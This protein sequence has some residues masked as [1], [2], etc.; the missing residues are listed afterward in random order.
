M[1]RLPNRLQPAWP[2]VKRLHRTGSLLSGY[3]VRRGGRLRGDRALPRRASLTSAATAEREPASVTLHQTGTVDAIR[4][5]MPAGTPPNHWV[6][7]KKRHIDVPARF[8]LE[9]ADGTVVGDYGANIT[10]AGTLDYETSEYFGISSWR[11]HPIFLRPRLPPIERAPGTVVALATRGGSINYYHFLLDVLPR[12]GV[13]QDTMPGRT[14]DALYV[15]AGAAWQRDLLAMAGLDGHTIIATGKHR[16][17]RAERLVVPC[18]PNPLEVAPQ[19][20]I[21]WLRAHLPPQG[22]GDWPKRIYVSRGTAPNTR[23]VI[24]EEALMRL[25]EERGF[26]H[27]DPLSLSVRDQIDQYHAAEVIVA[28]HGAALTNLVFARPGVKVLEIF[29]ASYVNQAF[30]AITQGIPGAQYAYF[31]AGDA[32]ALKPGSAVNKIQADIDLDP[33]AVVEALDRLIG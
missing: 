16:A 25:L 20:T 23:R 32:A 22:E 30:W 9:I 28:P 29:P 5:D 19:A 14:A 7:D 27:L 17:I 33:S 2:L 1:T 3:V 13:F 10:P 31:V 21:D 8:S 15:P 12:F 18:L 24:Q 11:E 26:V 6:F 4:R